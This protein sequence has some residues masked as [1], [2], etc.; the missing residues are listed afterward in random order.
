MNSRLFV[1]AGILIGFLALPAFADIYVW[2][3]ANGVKHFTNF[4]PPG[5]ASIFMVEPKLAS[6]STPVDQQTDSERLREAEKKIDDLNEEFTELKQQLEE[7][8]PSKDTPAAPD[9]SDPPEDEG[10]TEYD[11]DNT[12]DGYDRP[13]YEG[14]SYARYYKRYGTGGY[15]HRRHSNKHH[16]GYDYSQ[17]YK[18][19]YHKKHDRHYKSQRYPKHRRHY[20][21]RIAFKRRGQSIK[22]RRSGRHAGFRMGYRHRR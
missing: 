12:S 5:K 22:H 4:S 15:R 10:V 18:Y 7:Q 11:P 2:T 6:I 13:R 17:K 9:G 19:G 20:K 3:D 16:Y 14:Y 8:Q 21:H 1:Y